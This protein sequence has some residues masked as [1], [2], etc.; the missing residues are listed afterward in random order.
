[1]NK[2]GK[3]IGSGAKAWV[4]ILGPV[5]LIQGCLKESRIQT[6]ILMPGLKKKDKKN[7][8]VIG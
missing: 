7:F 8:V 1:M 2:V 6:F 5:N 3:N 4:K